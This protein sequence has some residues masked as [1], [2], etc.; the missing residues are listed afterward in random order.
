VVGLSWQLMVWGCLEYT[1]QLAASHAGAEDLLFAGR[2]YL[3]YSVVW[4]TV[5]L[6]CGCLYTHLTTVHKPS[7]PGYVM[8]V[9]VLLC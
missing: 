4:Y 1:S 6:Q 9:A 2:V 3:A 5:L 7:L 8:G